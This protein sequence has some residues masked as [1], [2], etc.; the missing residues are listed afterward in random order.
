MGE[1]MKSILVTGASKGIGLEFSRQY[2]HQGYRV[3]AASRKPENSLELQHLKSQYNDHLVIHQ[4][5][6]SDEE[7]RHNF[8]QA[9]LTQTEKLD[10]LI[11]NAGIIAGNEEYDYR[12]GN[13]KQEDIL[14]TLLVNSV[15]PLMITEKVFPLLSESTQPI[16]VN[17]TSDNGSISRRNSG[18]KYGYCASKAALNMITKILSNELIRNEIIVVALHPGW[19]KTPMTKNENAPLEPFE[20]IGGMMQVID[21]LEMKDTGRFLDWKGNDIP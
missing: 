1:V 9:L 16:V 13:L 5:D 14:R 11:N 20:S 17:I 2:L 15:A 3:F 7:S 18:G 8:Y 19:V 10:V 21:S 4:L 6:V 12:F